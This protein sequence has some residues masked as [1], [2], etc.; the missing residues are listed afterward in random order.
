MAKK[1]IISIRVT[2]QEKSDLQKK[3]EKNGFNS[4]SEYMLFVAK[5]AT[6]SVNVDRKI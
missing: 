1:S 2:D 6:I 4:L 3:S 5:N